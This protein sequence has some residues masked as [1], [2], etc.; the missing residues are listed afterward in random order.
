MGKN[1]MKK[2]NSVILNLFQNP[3]QK[4]TTSNQQTGSRNHVRDDGKMKGFTLIELLVVVLIIGILASVALPQYQ[5]AVL[6]SKLSS[7]LSVTKSVKDA[8]ELYY[9]ANGR[10]TENFHDLDI[11]GTGIGSSNPSYGD[12]GKISCKLYH[13]SFGWVWCSVNTPTPQSGCGWKIW[14]DHSNNPGK[15]QCVFANW[16]AQDSLCEKACKSTNFEF[17]GI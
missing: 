16:N 3:Y 13:T 6:K 2:F 17:G 14:L 15:I 4:K 9:L 5:V 7:V 1:E 12:F 11:E 10:Y 8:E